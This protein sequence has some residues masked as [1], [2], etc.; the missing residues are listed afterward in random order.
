MGLGARGRLLSTVVLVTGGA[1]R[2]RLGSA[3]AVVLPSNPEDRD[4]IAAARAPRPTRP[5][6]VRV[7]RLTATVRRPRRVPAVA[8]RHRRPARI[9]ARIAAVASK[10]ATAWAQVRS[11]A[12]N[13]VAKPLPTGQREGLLGRDDLADARL[14][15][16]GDRRR[17]LPGQGQGVA[18]KVVPGRHPTTP[19][20]LVYDATE[21]YNKRAHLLN[22]FALA[23]DWLHNDLTAD[24]RRSCSGRCSSSVASSSSTR[25]PRRGGERSPPARTSPATTARRSAWPGSPFGATCR[26]SRR[27]DRTRIAAGAQLLHRGIR[28]DRRRLRRHPLRQLRASDP[29]TVLRRARAGRAAN[30]LRHPRPPQHEWF[31]YEVL[32]GGGALNPLNDARYYELNEVHL[33]WA[34]ALRPEP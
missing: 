11:W 33:T 28:R 15:L 22:G 10:P 16:A 1:H 7:A 6:A 9:R 21:Y 31:A 23:Y 29:D 2:R 26:G 27:V 24:E 25:W 14:H 8:V 17:P 18:R 34:T 4:P 30:P 32:P 20:P 12:D 5:A 13:Y 19:R 3:D